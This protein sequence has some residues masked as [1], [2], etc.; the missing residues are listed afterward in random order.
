MKYNGIPYALILNFTLICFSGVAEKKWIGGSTGEWDN[1]THW[2]PAGIP[3]SGD[4]VVLNNDLNT[5]S[6]IITLPDHA[7][8]IHSLV[9]DPAEGLT[10]KLLL[11]SSNL[12]SPALLV[13]STGDAIIIGKGGVFQNSS[14]LSS[15][16]SIQINGMLC[17]YNGGSYVH[18]TRSSHAIEIVAKL[19][20]V[21]GTEKGAFEFN[22]PGG[23]YPISLSNR[24]YGTLILSSDASGGSQTYNA[25]GTNPV[26]INGDFCINDGVQ[27]NADLTKPLHINGD[28]IQNGGVFNVASQPNNNTVIIKGNLHQTSSGIITETSSGL[29]VIE[30]AGIINQQVSLAGAITNSVTFKINNANGVTLLK[31]F[32]LGFKLELAKGK[33]KTT[34]N[35]LLMLSDNTILEGGSQHSFVEGPM[36]KKGDDDFEFP[37]GRQGDYAPVKITGSS[38]AVSDEFQVEYFLANATTRYGNVIDDHSI[39]RVSTLEYWAVE[40]VSGSSSKKVSLSVGTYSNA[41]AL[42]KIVVTRWDPAVS[43]WKNEGNFSYQGVTTGIVQSNIVDNFGIFTLASTT[44]N[45]NPLSLSLTENR[46][47]LHAEGI[48]TK[49][50]LSGKL[51]MYPTFVKDH[52]V[53]KFH[54]T[55]AQTVTVMIIDLHGRIHTRI[56]RHLRLDDNSVDLNLGHLAAGG[57]FVQLYS[58]ELSK[59]VRFVKQ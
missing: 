13:N 59:S 29:P 53:I 55:K 22:V 46:F 21:A 24:T 11:P 45:Q 37:V 41:T 49:Q 31:H 14:G 35:S 56:N 3:V 27:F 51:S 26:V 50:S 1:I 2:Q 38:G 42:D 25:S 12:S 6:Y 34:A 40:R 44:E 10:I 9:I 36:R 19:S 4:T 54:L 43:M 15:G 20:T 28:Y 30:L 17:I 5:V 7:V 18:N 16:Q 57:Y 32:L 58:N 23:S 8:S 47:Q 48:T 52:A 33:L 39:V